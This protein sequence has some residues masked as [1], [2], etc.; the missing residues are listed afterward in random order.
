M[1]WFLL[2]QRF[3]NASEN[4]VACCNLCVF[5]EASGQTKLWVIDVLVEASFNVAAWAE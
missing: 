4:T 1:F 2:S 5:K 3:H